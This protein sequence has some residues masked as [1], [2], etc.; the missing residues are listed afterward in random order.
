LQN[1]SP[2]QSPPARGVGD[3]EL[4]DYIDLL[5]RRK[6]P[7]L[8]CALGLFTFSVVF[9]S[10]LQDFYRSETL[11]MVDPQQVP[12]SYVQST[13]SATI[14]DRLSTIQEQ[15]LSATHLQ[16]IIEKLG[17]YPEMQSKQTYQQIIAT[18]RKAITVD[19][20]NAT[21]R[22][23][24]SFRIAFQSKDPKTAS[25]VADELAAE[26]IN[27]NLQARIKQFDGAANFL[28][29]E[30]GETKAQLEAKEQELQQIRIQN[31]AVMPESRQF[32]LETL[33]NLR[34]QLRSAQDRISRA[35]EQKAMLQQYAPTVDLDSDS[36][37]S[38][39][40]PFQSRIQKLEAQLSELRAR[41]GAGHPDVRKVASQLAELRA[42]EA[43]E[44]KQSEGT[45]VP[46]AP[47]V[48]AAR[49]KNPVLQAQEERLDQE[50]KEQTELAKQYQDQINAHTANLEQGPVFEQRIA[51]LMRD[52][53]SLRAHYQDLLNKKLSAD[54]ARELEGRQQGER[55]VVLDAA[56]IPQSPAGPNRPLI[57]AGGLILGLLA[58]VA[59][60]LAMEF[61]DESVRSEREAATLL[62]KTVLA[63]VPR[64]YGLGE[65][66]K[67]RLKLTGAFVGTV[68]S[69]IILGYAV[70]LLKI[71]F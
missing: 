29:S 16:H 13:V 42:Q 34:V 7:L 50:I 20:V 14:Q 46:K 67:M 61:S 71:G 68:A 1:Q 57:C 62:G 11:I 65:L 49:A 17:L 38:S 36:Y 10:R 55:F 48:T 54:M 24:S 23:L 21:D 53:D 41:Y 5:R 70:S 58:G 28:E 15:V 45:V 18:M 43:N 8:L 2:V 12:S 4:H 31:A 37:S 30:L 9:A 33:N 35:Q 60:I 66:R 26:F 47:P 25:K 40:S 6:V 27:E 64:I 56:P 22:R 63:G 44:K 39:I 69:G 19:V 3:F 52:Y 32:H 59:L 51:S